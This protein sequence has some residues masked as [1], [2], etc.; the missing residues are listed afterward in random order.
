MQSCRRLLSRWRRQT[1]TKQKHNELII[2]NLYSTTRNILWFILDSHSF[3]IHSIV[4]SL[5]HSE[6]RSQD[7]LHFEDFGTGL[8]TV[9]VGYSRGSCPH[10]KG[11]QSSVRKSRW[12]LYFRLP[13]IMESS[14]RTAQKSQRKARTA[15]V[16]SL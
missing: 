8:V 7:R 12:G 14:P 2:N 6:K 9:L 1:K 15:V 3:P 11:S 5:C 10:N 16:M 4:N 13:K